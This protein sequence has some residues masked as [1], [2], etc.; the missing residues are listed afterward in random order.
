[1]SAGD[2]GRIVEISESEEFKG[3]LHTLF[4]LLQL[5]ELAVSLLR[6]FCLVKRVKTR[7]LW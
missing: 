4:I 5:R 7:L 2:T 6:V 1:M 3:L